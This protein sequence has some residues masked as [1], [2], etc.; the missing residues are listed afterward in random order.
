MKISSVAVALR[1][2]PGFSSME[3]AITSVIFVDFADASA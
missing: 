2:A 1:L 3:S